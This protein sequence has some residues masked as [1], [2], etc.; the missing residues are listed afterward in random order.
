MGLQV[1]EGLGHHLV[2]FRIRESRASSGSHVR[3]VICFC[4]VLTVSQATLQTSELEDLGIVTQA[5]K[6]DSSKQLEC[7]LLDCSNTRVMCLQN[8]DS[9]ELEWWLSS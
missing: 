1:E 3:T 6:P 7:G 4:E 2:F 8:Y 5:A 9:L